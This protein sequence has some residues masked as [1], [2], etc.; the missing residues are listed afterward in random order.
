MP[1]TAAGRWSAQAAPP[2]PLRNARAGTPDDPNAPPP[3]R[4]GRFMDCVANLQA[5]I[6]TAEG[7]RNGAEA[8]TDPIWRRLRD[9][10]A[11]T[12]VILEDMARFT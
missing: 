8:E 1:P 4:P 9:I 3:V 2:P 7:A 12:L 6:A 11:D 5:D 10:R